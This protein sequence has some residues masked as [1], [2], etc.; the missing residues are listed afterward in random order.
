MITIDSNQAMFIYSFA[1]TM[2]GLTLYVVAQT[3]G[4]YWAMRVRR[5]M[6]NRF[7]EAIKNSL[8]LSQKLVVLE[9]KAKRLNSQ[10]N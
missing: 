1:G 8:I 9:E 10:W 6:E 2:L 5:R 7:A 3:I 4:E